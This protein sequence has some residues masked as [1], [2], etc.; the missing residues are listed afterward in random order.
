MCRRWN[1]VIRCFETAL[2][3]LCMRHRFNKPLH[4]MCVPLR[5]HGD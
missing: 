1:L 2:L 4:A 3:D 5:V